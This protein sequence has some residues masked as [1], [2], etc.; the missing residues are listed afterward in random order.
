MPREGPMDVPA[1]LGAARRAVALV[2]LIGSVA[3]LAA[4]PAARA[5]DGRLL[6]SVPVTF[7]PDSI[8]AMEIRAPAIR[9]LLEQVEI[10]AITYRSDGLRVKGY[11]AQPKAGDAKLPCV[12]W[13]RGGNREFG[14]LTNR[15]AAL[16]LGKIASWGYVVVASQYR[17][18]AGGEGAEEFGGR[19]VDDVLNL[20][21]L[22]RS[23]PRADA[24]RIGMYGW[25]RGGMMTYLALARTDTIAAAIVGAGLSDAF[26]NV[27]RRP[28]MEGVFA[29]LA[30]GWAKD[31]EGALAARSAVRWVEKLPPRTPIL[32]LQGTAD[33]RV[34]PNET[35]AMASRL[36]ELKRPFRLVMLEGGDHGLSEHRAE[37]DRLA[38]DWLDRY[39]RDRR[40]WPSLEPHG[41]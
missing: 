37:V 14:A 6:E 20:V 8:A 2:L 40:P 29:E 38:K 33:W 28:E 23:L 25:S 10:R 31:R 36:L 32:L 16:N 17:G 3:G 12:I 24:T 27:S 30:P 15:G 21:P 5:Q 4:A 19:D 9:A 1:R 18:N 11:L 41:P 22:L 34:P 7:P 13:N 35:L 39:V 26:D